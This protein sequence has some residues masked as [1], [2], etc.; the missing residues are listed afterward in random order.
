MD[1]RE[2]EDKNCELVRDYLE[3]QKIPFRNN[4][5]FEAVVTV[6][7][8]KNPA[9]TATCMV[10]ISFDTYPA[11]KIWLFGDDFVAKEYPTEFWGGKIDVRIVGD[12]LEIR[13]KHPHE[14]IG[15]YTVKITCR[16]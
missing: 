5:Q 1:Y 11:L 10:N 7:P 15:K 6:A 14:V 16:K 3:K 8:A 2:I 4:V 9:R 12:T 13:G